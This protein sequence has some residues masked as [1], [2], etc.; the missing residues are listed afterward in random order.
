MKNK[1]IEHFD[2]MA[3]EKGHAWW[4]SKTYSGRKRKEVR[5]EMAKKYLGNFSGK[6]ILEIGCASGDY[7][8]VLAEKFKN[9]KILATDISGGQIE[10]ARSDI[11]NINVEF[12]ID[13]SENM[14]L[15]DDSIDCIIA[16]SILHHV[17]VGKCL[18]ECKRVLK[19]GGQIFFTEPNMLNPQVFI[20]KNVG[21]IKKI[22]GH[23]PDELA[24]YRWRIKKE[25]MNIGFTQVKVLNFD[26]LHPATPGALTRSI[27]LLS[28]ILEKIPVIK[29]VSGSL[30]IN[31]KKNE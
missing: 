27:N 6:V 10:I 9:N 14:S 2:R 16:N 22:A 3:K 28:R 24:F 30:I 15:E 1:E 26:F 8:K 31:G 7:T 4:G 29:E 18:K 11:K 25:I 21:F 20:E 23:S 12:K 5:A 19:K 17:D 13:D